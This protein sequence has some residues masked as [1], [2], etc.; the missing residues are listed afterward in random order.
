M[1]RYRVEVRSESTSHALPRYAMAPVSTLAIS[2]E[3][4]GRRGTS[5]TGAGL[6]LTSGYLAAASRNAPRLP[7]QSDDRKDQAVVCI[8]NLNMRNVNQGA[9]GSVSAPRRNVRGKSGLNRSSLNQG[10]FG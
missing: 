5:T 3:E 6:K 7:T 9:A 2:G 1:C 4:Y 10:Y 8:E